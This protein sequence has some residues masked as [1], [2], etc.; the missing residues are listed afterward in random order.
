MSAPDTNIKT[1]ER[2][3]KGALGGMKL[4]LGFVAVILLIFVGYLFFASDGPEEAE[5]QVEVGPGIEVTEPDNA[6][7]AGEVD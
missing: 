2:R 6:I 4:V 3:H 7:P 5:S 1:Q